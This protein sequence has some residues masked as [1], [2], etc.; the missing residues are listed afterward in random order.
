LASA[1]VSAKTKQRLKEEKA[2]LNPFA[3][4][5]LLARG[6]KEIDAVRQLRP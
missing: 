1:Q 3:L 6:L 2:S 5:K 4:Q